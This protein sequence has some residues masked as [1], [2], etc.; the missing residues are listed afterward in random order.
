MKT[1]LIIALIMFQF[2]SSNENEVDVNL[3]DDDSSYPIHEHPQWDLLDNK[4][5]AKISQ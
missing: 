3:S 5:K 2:V 4:A 1:A